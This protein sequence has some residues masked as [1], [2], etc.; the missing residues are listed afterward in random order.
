M[1]TQAN[2]YAVEYAKR[3]LARRYYREYL[4][5]VYP[6]YWKRTRM[7][8]F[9][10]D[11]V[12]KFLET[13]TGHAYDILCIS[14]PP[15]HGKSMVLT[16]TLPSWVLGHRPD[17]N[18]ILAA[19]DAE[20]SERFCRRNKEKIRRYG[21]ALF[22]M[23]IGSIDRA[24]EFELAGHTGRVICRGIMSGI[25]GN[26]A[27]LIIIDDP[28]K[29]QR[30]ADSPTYRARLWNEWQSSL[31]SR[32]AAGAKVIIIMTR[33]S[34]DDLIARVAQTETSVKI[35]RLPVEAEE[36]DL[37][38]RKVGEPLC[39]ELGK[40]EQW[41]KDFKSS[42]INDPLGGQRA[43]TALYQCSPRIEDG[44]LV[45]R[46]WW[47][48]YDTDEVLKFGTELISVDAAFKDTGD[49]VSIQVWG[50]RGQDYY[51]RYCLNQRLNFPGTL[52]AIRATAK[53]YPEAR[54]ILI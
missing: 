37:L 11:E 42:Y 15:Q 6:G 32:L 25:T 34:P 22:G 29:N 53:L 17:S 45:N 12:Q 13:D 52:A 47:R 50:K 2:E 39:P 28:I 26:A 49:Y 5:Y 9:L 8:N 30:E 18:I 40:G 19:Y 1:A 43:W 38:G 7:A 35:L 10:A 14:T 3:E 20:L 33:W 46:K 21:K 31:K 24:N 51:L 16:E 44:N 36:G 41:L 48:S 4:P 54:M 23:G 27:G